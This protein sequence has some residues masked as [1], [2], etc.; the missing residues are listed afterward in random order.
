MGKLILSTA[1][2][3]DA[4]TDVGDWFV[5]GDGHD[6][7]SREQF[8]EAEAMLLGRTTFE[9]LAGFWSTQEGPWADRINPMPKVV[10]SRSVS[11]PLDWNGTAIAGEAA[12]TVPWAKAEHGGDLV[13][14][15][16]GELARTLLSHGLVDELR[17]WVHP[18]VAGEGTRP[19]GG[20]RV[21]MRLLGS[22]AFDSGVVV[23]RYE[24]TS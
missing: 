16:C 15:G 11:G 3:V 13:I 17:F 10:V 7:A 20:D 4:V 1:M 19:F 12:E 18:S 5:S 6:A 24:P 21:P 8:E 22:T 14:V 23:L 9:G 2:S